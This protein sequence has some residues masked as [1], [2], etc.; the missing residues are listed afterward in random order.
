MTITDAVYAT[1]VP[2]P[3]GEV[4]I[5]LWGRAAHHGVPLTLLDW[6]VRQLA[7]PAWEWVTERLEELRVEYRVRAGSLGAWIEGEVIS[8][9]VAGAGVL[10]R[11]IPAWLTGK[12]A[13]AQIGMAATGYVRSA[14]VKLSPLA[15]ERT[16]SRALAALTYEGGERD[17]DPSTAAFLYGIV[18]GLD[19]AAARD[20]KAKAPVRTPRN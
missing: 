19:E 14:S 6:D 9:Q 2:S 15:V 7:P 4:A 11:P 20:P 10:C 17:D 18:I 13:W 1:A 12:E 8:H 16:K 5:M 3:R